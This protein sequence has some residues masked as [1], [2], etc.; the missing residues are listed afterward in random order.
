MPS[1]LDLAARLSTIVAAQ[2]EILTRANDPIAV[3][4]TALTQTKRI[5]KASGAALEEIEGDQRVYRAVSGNALAPP[6][7]AL[8][9]GSML[10][11]P[12]TTGGKAFGALRVFSERPNAFDD[13]DAYTVELLAGMISAALMHAREFRDHRASEARY[14]MLFEQNVAGVFRT[15]RDGRILD[16][17]NAFVDYLGYSSR[18]ELL[19]RRSWDLYPQRSDREAFL[20]ALD[21]ERVMTN[22]RLHLKKKDGSDV[23]GIVNVSVIPA[24]DGDTQ[25][26]GTLVAG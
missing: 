18:E 9:V 4:D 19:E 3:M 24:D 1:T 26:L 13:L 11:A 15:T 20:A 21:R 23:T 5:T 14:R 8:A 2:Q 17:N 6:G 25:L 16:C 10:T 22:V 12:L 7:M